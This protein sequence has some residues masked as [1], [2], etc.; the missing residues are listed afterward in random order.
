MNKKIVAVLIATM[1]LGFFTPIVLG[2]DTESVVG[3]F[4]P[5]STIAISVNSST[6]SFGSVALDSNTTRYVNVSN[7]G[8]TAVNVVAQ[9]MS[10]GANWS[11]EEWDETPEENNF[12]VGALA[13]AELGGTAF[14]FEDAN[15][16]FTV[17]SDMEAT[18]TNYSNCNISLH[19]SATTSLDAYEEPFYFNF[20]A[21]AAS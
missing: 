2:D 20:T 4:T 8:D 14:S 12:Q 3:T 1:L 17:D 13:T 9:A 21:S 15:S 11:L 6:L 19:I 10:A 7:T 16:E 18:A 5:T